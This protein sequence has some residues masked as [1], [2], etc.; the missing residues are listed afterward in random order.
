MLLMIDNY[1]SFTYNLVQYFGELG[2]DVRTVRNDEITL[3]EIAAMK[4]DRICVSPG[5]CSPQEAGISVPLLKRFAGEMPIL[6]ICLGHQSIGAAFGGKIVRAKQV[7]HGKTSILN[8][9]GVGVFRDL[10]NPYTVIRYHS[11]AIERESLPDCLEVTA[12][13]EDGEIMGVRHKEMNVQG[14]QFHPES[15]LTEQ[16]HELLKNFLEK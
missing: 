7:M 8:H 5:P 12:W 1:D 6:G 4:P 2:E 16:G 15:I 10:P 14:V 3:D 9:I 13:T 11:L